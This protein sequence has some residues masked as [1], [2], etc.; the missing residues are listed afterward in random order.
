MFT[1]QNH[2]FKVDHIQSLPL[3]YTLKS[4]QVIA[5]EHT[6]DRDFISPK[7]ALNRNQTIDMS[8]EVKQESAVEA[9][10]VVETSINGEANGAAQTTKVAPEL[11][12]EDAAALSAKVAKQGTCRLTSNLVQL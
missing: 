2:L 12:P 7:T 3:L 5:Y 8:D 10:P 6:I 11:S 4:N 9:K 1:I